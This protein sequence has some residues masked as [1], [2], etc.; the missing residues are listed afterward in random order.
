[1]C[2]R[3]DNVHV[4]GGEWKSWQIKLRLMRGIHDSAV[5]VADSDGLGGWAFVDDMGIDRTKVCG[6]AAV[7]DCVRI[8]R[9]DGGGTYSTNCS[10]TTK[11]TRLVTS[12]VRQ[13][14]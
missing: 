4:A 9:D 1:M 6:A 12:N 13:W 11:T 7:G 2:K 5:R 14:W 8:R 3:G 10:E